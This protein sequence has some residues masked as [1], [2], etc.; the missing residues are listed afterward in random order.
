M[1]GPALRRRL[2]VAAALILVCAAAAAALA[3]PAHAFIPTLEPT[4]AKSFDGGTDSTDRAYDIG[5]SGNTVWVCGAW[6]EGA[7]L[8]DMALVRVPT[9]G[10]RARA[11][12]WKGLRG[13][14]AALALATAPDGSVYTAGYSGGATKAD[15]R[16]VKWSSLGKV[17]WSSRIDGPA[18]GND[19]ATDVAVDGLGRVTVCGYAVTSAGVRWLVA[20]YSK[21]GA[22][23]WMR[24]RSE[25]PGVAGS[26]AK[27]LCVDGGGSVYVTGS[28]WMGSGEYE[29]LTVKYSRSGEVVWTR[30]AASD[31]GQSSITDCITRCPTGGVYVGGKIS[32]SVT[33][34]DPLLIRYSKGG[35]STTFSN[36][37]DLEGEGDLHSLAVASDGS[38][39]AG[40]TQAED[41]ADCPK[42]T[43]YAAAGAPLDSWFWPLSDC[44]WPAEIASVSA[45]NAGHVYWAGY[46][47]KVGA[48][49][50]PI[51]D[52]RSVSAGDLA[53]TGAWSA[54]GSFVE[55][56]DCVVSGTT[57]YV[58]GVH[59]KGAQGTNMFVLKYAP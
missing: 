44:T 2:L 43:R 18:H 55:A 32:R 50:K 23:R 5:V 34:W 49:M 48:D 1:L 35:E 25:R 17:L 11:F 20:G 38:V 31:E 42:V 51:I 9:I 28:R 27:A 41:H 45:D 47:M 58:A 16:L 13:S 39:I 15:L 12:T 33:Y 26:T 56:T 37:A 6:R 22:L 54:G 53:W 46:Q 52:C 21:S 59:D 30:V 36:G 57:L 7:S 8:Q 40:G 14:D 3:A 29:S 10:L 19:G 24:R 4:W